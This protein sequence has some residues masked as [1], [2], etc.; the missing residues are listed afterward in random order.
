MSLCV[1]VGGRDLVVCW[2]A[3]P[4]TVVLAAPGGGTRV[5]KAS[6]LP[7][8]PGIM[9]L[10]V[11]GGGNKI[12][13]GSGATHKWQHSVRSSGKAIVEGR[14]W[15]LEQLRCGSILRQGGELW[16]GECW[17]GRARCG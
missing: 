2:A 3:V 10:A 1:G 12:P 17:G 6:V 14:W 4:G 5:L 13:P 15:G 9:V 8:V 16:G 7:I 11:P